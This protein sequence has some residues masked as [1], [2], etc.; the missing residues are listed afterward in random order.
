MSSALETDLTSIGQREKV[1]SERRVM[2]MTD[3]FFLANLPS[4]LTLDNG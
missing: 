3:P 2:T 1:I 4:D